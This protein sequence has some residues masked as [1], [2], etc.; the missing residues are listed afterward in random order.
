MVYF[1]ENLDV[2]RVKRCHKPLMTGYLPPIKM[3][4]WGLVYYCF[5]NIKANMGNTRTFG[6]NQKNS[7]Y[8]GKEWQNSLEKLGI[9][10]QKG[11][12]IRNIHA[13]RMK[14]TWFKPSEAATMPSLPGNMSSACEC[15]MQYKKYHEDCALG[16][17]TARARCITRHPL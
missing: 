1:M 11:M 16:Q 14:Q 12:W 3:V 17:T 6:G 9:T 10:I 7:I 8:Y 5:T 13:I 15:W 4:L 2:M